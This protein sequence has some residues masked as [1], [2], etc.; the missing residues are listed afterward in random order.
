VTDHNAAAVAASGREF[1]VVAH[2]GRDNVHETMAV[3]A[4]RCAEAG[5]GL[6]VIDH[7]TMPSHP[8]PQYLSTVYPLDPAELRQIGADVAV[9][10]GNEQS[11]VGCE[12]IIVLGGDGTFLRAAEVA[13]P[14][15]VPVLGI[16]LGHIGFLAEAEAHRVDEVIGK[17]IRREYEIEDRMTLDVSVQVD[18]EV[19][20]K[21]WAL[22]EASIQNL[23]RQ[24]VLEL[25]TE[26]DGRPVSAFGADGILVST[27]TGSTAYAFSAGGPVMWPDLEAILLVPSNAHALFARPMITSPQSRVAIEVL[28]RGQD[29]LLSCDG[30]RNFDVPAGGRIE[31]VRGAK[32]VHWVRIDSDPFADRLVRKFQLPVTGWRGRQL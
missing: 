15:S 20:A 27:P 10:A 32:P 19:V 11:A 7:D 3:I 2:T 13:H 23:S 30:R 6:R 14:V 1:L 9:T 31:V 16:N 21:S 18:G 5:V 26:V 25:I 22:N 4:K 17:L 29:A 12:V 8:G 28:A 24:G